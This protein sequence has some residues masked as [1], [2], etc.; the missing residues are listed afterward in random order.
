MAVIQPAED[1]L[2]LREHA[3]GVTVEQTLAATGAPLWAEGEVPEMRRA[4]ESA[5]AGAGQAA[6]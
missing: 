3:P 2:V 5:A 4:P 1:G 6:R